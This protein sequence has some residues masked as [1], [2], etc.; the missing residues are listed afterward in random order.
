MYSAPVFTATHRPQKRAP[1]NQPIH[2]HECGGRT[3]VA[4]RTVRIYRVVLIDNHGVETNPPKA[5][6]Q[7]VF[8]TAGA[9]GAAFEHI[10]GGGVNLRGQFH[11]DGAAAPHWIYV[12]R[13]RDRIDWPDRTT[14]SNPDPTSI[15]ND[16]DITALFEPCRL[17]PISKSP[18]V[19]IVRSYAGALPSALEQWLS[20]AYGKVKKDWTIELRPV[21]RDDQIKRLKESVGVAKI[22][23]A[24]EGDV[25]ADSG[26]KISKAAGELQDAA[27]FPVRTEIVMSMGNNKD[28]VAFASLKKLAQRVIKGGQATRATVTL[29]EEDSDGNIQRDVVD[30]FADKLAFAFEVASSNVDDA[31]YV[32]V[33]E[34]GISEFKKVRKSN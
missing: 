7:K 2:L 27:G 3:F 22:A 28:Q 1:L 15:A 13:E 4:E 12:G 29:L 31:E 19:A 14:T 26:G 34:A 20:A 5:F 18:Y 6:W 9:G 32:R 10:V 16:A 30:M 17:M 11:R 21:T 25:S 23:V 24:L 33:L 8:D